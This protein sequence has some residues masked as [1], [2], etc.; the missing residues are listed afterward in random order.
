MKSFDQF[1]AETADDQAEYEKIKSRLDRSG[2]KVRSSSSRAMDLSLKAL[3]AGDIEKH[4]FWL[5]RAF[6]KLTGQ[7]E[8][9][10]E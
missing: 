6:K 10:E 7:A 9:G 1:I 2:T 8:D 5:A 3:K 4:K